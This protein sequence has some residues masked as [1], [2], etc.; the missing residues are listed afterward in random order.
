MADLWVL[1]HKTTGE[2]IP[3]QEPAE[4]WGGA[5]HARGFVFADPEQEYERL[6]IQEEPA[7]AGTPRERDLRM[8]TVWRDRLYTPGQQVQIMALQSLA[9]EHIRLLGLRAAGQVLNEEQTLIANNSGL[10]VLA[11]LFR[12]ARSAEMTELAHPS[13]AFAQQ[14]FLALGVFGDNTEVAESEATRV[15][16]GL[17]PTGVEVQYERSA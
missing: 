5:W 9:D 3:T 1:K 7:P 12:E 8:K 13:W 16:E 14:Q 10:S 17:P 15:T 4:W 2:V 6:L 11:V